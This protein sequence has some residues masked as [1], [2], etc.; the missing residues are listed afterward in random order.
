MRMGI[1]TM[2]NA[3]ELKFELMSRKGGERWHEYAARALYKKENDQNY[4]K[5]YESL[6]S[7]QLE[8]MYNVTFMLFKYLYAFISVC[9]CFLMEE[10]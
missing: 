2:S 10:K 6:N 8:W 1:R 7:P 4:V 3:D 9:S 5:F